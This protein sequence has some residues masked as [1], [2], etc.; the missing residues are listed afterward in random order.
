[1]EYGPETPLRPTR[2]WQMN[3]RGSPLKASDFETRVLIRTRG[4]PLS[5]VLVLPVASFT[6]HGS[7][8]QT[9]AV[10][11]VFAAVVVDRD[12]LRTLISKGLATSEN[13]FQTMSDAREQAETMNRNVYKAYQDH[14]ESAALTAVRSWARA[15]TDATPVVRIEAAANSRTGL[16]L[17]NRA[18]ALFS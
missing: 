12:S 1:M 6:G 5:G 7:A 3:S 4:K 17:K 18:A 10:Y 8:G 11:P 2:D 9:V 16:P 15:D 14:Y 13:M